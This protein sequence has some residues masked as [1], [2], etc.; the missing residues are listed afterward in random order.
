MLLTI[1]QVLTPEQVAH[2]RER[3]ATAAWADGRATAG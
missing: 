1:P 3:L 2:C